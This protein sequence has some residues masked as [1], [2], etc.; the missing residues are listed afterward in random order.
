MTGRAT[1]YGLWMT[2]WWTV[3][4]VLG[5]SPA[6]AQERP[7]APDDTLVT[8]R[9]QQVLVP[10]TVADRL[11]RPVTN[12]A[13]EDVKLFEDGVEQD[14]VSLRPAP[15]LPLTA[16]VVID[17]SGSMVNRL[18]LAKRATGD[19]LER[20][21]RRPQDR[22]ALF[23]CQQDVLLAH[24]PTG[25]AAALRRALADLDER[26][27]TPLGRT[28]PFNPAKATPPGTALYAAVYAA[29]D[30]LL[31]DA[32]EDDRRR[33]VVIV[34]DGFDSEGLVRPG[35][36]V[37]HAWRGGVGVYALGIGTPD[38]TAADAD[39]TV[40]RAELERLC[41]STGGRAFFPRLDRDFFTAF[42]QIETDL[43]QCFVL[44]YT[45]TNEAASFRTIRI[46]IPRHPDWKVRHRAGYYTDAP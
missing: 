9:A 34:S 24:P 22:A 45:P 16:A 8:L 2:A 26:L 41:A 28:P 11:N 25:D 30:L 7:S 31:A 15:P 14:I 13:A 32:G 17:C 38:L 20:L 10:F 19:F 6:R 4:A 29:I 33:I 1:A 3:A 42:E 40:N 12:L 37:E 46:E 23:A 44:A 39:R 5:P 35:E 21:L 36:V 27:P 43:R 18:A